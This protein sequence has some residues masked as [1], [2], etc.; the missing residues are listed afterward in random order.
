M[1]IVW[2]EKSIQNYFAII[3]YLVLN[4]NSEIAL[5]FDNQLNSLIERIQSFEEI[6]PKSKILN[7]HKCLI[8]KHNSLIYHILN[9]KLLI[10]AIV[11]NRSNHPF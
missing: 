2:S 6:C 11:D 3:D 5:K 10:V 4:W 8:N 7:F 9:D 1:E